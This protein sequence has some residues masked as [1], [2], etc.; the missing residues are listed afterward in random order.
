MSDKE[1]TETTS[2][3]ELA[4]IVWK[5]LEAHNIT[6]VLSGGS[7]V[8]I[9]TGANVYESKDLDFI[10]PADH[11]RILEVM[12]KIEFR[13]T[14]KYNKNLMH[15]RTKILVEFPTGPVNL[16][17][18]PI[19]Y[20]K[21]DLQEVEGEKIRMLSPTQSVMDRL[22]GY[23]SINKDIQGLDQALWICERHPVNYSQIKEWAKKDGQ[24]N[25]LEF[26]K[27]CEYCERGIKRYN[28][29]LPKK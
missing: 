26:D 3:S 17:G 21:I 25:Q 5:H 24:A 2:I 14:S 12:E 11:K 8:T 23:L 10:S 15:P 27:I 7:V 28:S 9:Y 4:V 29:G 1:I 22:L 16:G 18:A 19:R 20:D 13:P 6:A